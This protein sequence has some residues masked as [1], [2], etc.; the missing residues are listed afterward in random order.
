MTLYRVGVFFPTTSLRLKWLKLH[1]NQ[2]Q[3]ERLR[4]LKIIDEDVKFLTSSNMSKIRH[5]Q[6]TFI[7]RTTQSMQRL[8]YDLVT[9]NPLQQL[10]CGDRQDYYNDTL[11][12]NTAEWERFWHLHYLPHHPLPTNKQKYRHKLLD[13]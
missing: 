13:K 7:R 10:Q 2:F 5:S 11:Y 3:K 8:G 12:D 9:L 4:N 1:S 6:I